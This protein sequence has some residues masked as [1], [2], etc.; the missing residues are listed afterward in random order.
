LQFFQTKYSY[1]FSDFDNKQQLFQQATVAQLALVM[2][3]SV[4]TVRQ[5]PTF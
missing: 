1:P 2:D 4:F 3:N 5:E